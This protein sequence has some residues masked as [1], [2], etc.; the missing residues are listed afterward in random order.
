MFE[1]EESVSFLGRQG[2]EGDLSEAWFP[3]GMK[4]S[5]IAV[6]YLYRIADWPCTDWHFFREYSG[7]MTL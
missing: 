4:L 2:H 1:G 5:E 7:S 3:Q 6:S